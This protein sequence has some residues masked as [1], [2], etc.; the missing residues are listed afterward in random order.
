MTKQ[1]ALQQFNQEFNEF[2]KTEIFPQD[3]LPEDFNELAHVAFQF[4]SVA[5]L[6]RAYGF[7]FPEYKVLVMKTKN[8]SLFELAAIC[9]AIEMRSPWELSRYL[10]E[11]NYYTIQE[12]VYDINLEWKKIVEPRR[13]SMERKIHL[14]TGTS[15]R[16][17]RG[18]SY[19]N[20]K[21]LP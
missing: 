15:M 3:L 17:D 12:T 20:G 5:S 6:Q 11:M 8:Y 1:E 4:E 9:N 16:T 13:E 7:S 2:L 10:K 19:I 18:S 21:K 14:A